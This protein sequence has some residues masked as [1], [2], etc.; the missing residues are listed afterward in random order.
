MSPRNAL[1]SPGG[2]EDAG[3][4]CPLWVRKGWAGWGSTGASI[5]GLCWTLRPG[6]L[7]PLPGPPHLYWS[8]A[9][10]GMTWHCWSPVG[11]VTATLPGEPKAL[12]AEAGAD[13]LTCVAAAEECLAPAPHQKLQ[14][15][16]LSL[17]QASGG[18]REA[19]ARQKMSESHS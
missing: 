11:S 17:G 19:I 14:A 8:Q 5:P 13:T 1:R 12:S 9:A 16:S 10:S 4:G 18:L 15:V 2:P 7:Y 6:F 3:A